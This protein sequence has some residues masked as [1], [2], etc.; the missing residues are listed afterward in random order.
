MVVGATFAEVALVAIALIFH[1]VSRLILVASIILLLFPSVL[2]H[3]FHC[4][5]MCGGSYSRF[6]SK[7]RSWRRF[8]SSCGGFAEHA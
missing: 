2:G 4:L 1:V 3:L 5:I 7:F 8:L 6:E